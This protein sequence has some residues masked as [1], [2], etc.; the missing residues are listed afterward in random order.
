MGKLSS[1]AYDE[2]NRI[3]TGLAHKA[4]YRA[5]YAHISKE[6]WEAIFGPRVVEAAGKGKLKAIL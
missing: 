5:S 4:N 6:Q 3:E 1:P 2:A